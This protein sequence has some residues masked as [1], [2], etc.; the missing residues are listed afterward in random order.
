MEK[1][2]LVKIFRKLSKKDIRELRKLVRSDYFNQRADVIRLFD[3]LA[4]AMIQSDCDLSKPE[5]YK[6]VFPGQVY[7]DSLMRYAMSFLLKSN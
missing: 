4:A 5:V 6:H 3:Y 2:A 7:D 1:S